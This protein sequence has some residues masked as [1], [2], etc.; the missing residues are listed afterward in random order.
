MTGEEFLE[1]FQWREEIREQAKKARSR[2][3]EK[4]KQQ[5]KPQQTMETEKEKSLQGGKQPT[6][7]EQWEEWEK[8]TFKPL[9]PL[10]QRYDPL[11]QEIEQRRYEIAKDVMAGLLSYTGD[12]VSYE[13]FARTAV[14]AADALLTELY[15]SKAE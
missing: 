6:C 13:V 14:E 15:K 2:E 12:G 10:E 11:V 3:A 1:M 9:D 8:N 5:T 4:I 7:Q